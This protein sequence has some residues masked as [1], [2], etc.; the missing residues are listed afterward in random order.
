MKIIEIS[1]TNINNLKG[2]H[3][4]SF[5]KEPLSSAGIFA[6][7]GPTGAGKSSI[8]D[9]ITLALFNR[10]PRFKKSIT[11][12]EMNNAGSVMTHHCTEA[13]ASIIYE[14]KGIRFT[15][16]WSI[17]KTR[18]GNLKDYEMFIYNAQGQ[19]L[20]LKKSDVPTKNE[21]IIGLKYDQFI[22]SILLSQGEFAK[23]IKAD[24]NERGE[25]LENITGTSIYRTLGIKAFE[26]HK[27]IKIRITQEK[28]L[29]GNLSIL[30]KEDQ[31]AL[32]QEITNCEKQAIDL[33]K[34]ITKETHLKQIK[35][36]L[37]NINIELE[38]KETQSLR[39]AKQLKDFSPSLEKIKLHQK[40]NPIQA[41]LTTYKNAINNANISEKNLQDYSNQ[42]EKSKAD[43]N[44]TINEMSTLTHQKVDES[45]F[46]KTM[47]AFEKEVN[48]LD[49]ELR[50]ILKKGQEEREENIQLQ[51]DHQFELEDKVKPT[52][53]LKILQ[54]KQCLLDEIILNGK[55]DA[56]ANFN[57]YRK[58]LD[59]DKTRRNNFRELA[60][61]HEHLQEIEA[62]LV[63]IKES[64]E[65]LNRESKNLSPLIKKTKSLILSKEENI[66]LLLKQKE[67]ALK[68]ASLEDFRK[69]LT[70]ESPCP[71]CG[72]TEHPYTTHL[73]D[74]Q[75]DKINLKIENEQTFIK[76]TRVELNEKEAQFSKITANLELT[77]NQ[78]KDFSQKK[79]TTQENIQKSQSAFKFKAPKT[80]EALNGQIEQ[81]SQQITVDE[82]AIDAILE[83]EAIKELTKSFKQIQKIGTEYKNLKIKR[84]KKFK[85]ED[86][87]IVTNK[88]Q[89]IFQKNKS[90]ITEL[91]TVILRE[92]QSLKRDKDLVASI[93]KDL[94]PKVKNLGFDNLFAVQ[95]HFLGEDE[96]NTL[97]QQLDQ[98]NKTS[99]QNETELKT[100]SLK[101]KQLLQSDTEQEIDLELIS[102]NLNLNK[103][104]K[105]QL[106]KTTG[107]LQQRLKRDIEDRTKIES[108]QKQLDKLNLDLE[109]WG[110]L[111]EMIGDANGNKFANFAQGL[112]LQNLLVFA[113]RRLQTLSDRYLLDK[114]TDDGALMIVDLY[115]GNT[116]RSVTTLSGGESF[117]V[118][119]A[120]ALS[121]S[122]MAS[123]SVAL[124]SLF[125]DEGFGTLDQDTLEMA[126]NTLEKLQSESQKTIG[127]ISHVETLKER[128]HVQIQLKKNAQGYSKIEIA[129]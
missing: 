100:L 13:N 23:F 45:N 68:I 38:K 30:S 25:L 14:I 119:L 73:D 65:K 87:N 126:M 117:L 64:I 11:K 85:G 101:A 24:K 55:L 37:K 28:E 81:I 20:D 97:S 121:L 91:E 31:E 59:E 110:L 77:N 124:E 7:T 128:I 50:N 12:N 46:M 32:A 58:K 123:K 9:V 71:L 82:K 35:S 109:K 63:S 3:Q 86:V 33:E 94:S 21:Q 103:E 49:N 102:R 111:K 118:S 106:N 39:I 75:Q 6:I 54:E 99:T 76:K 62:Q 44:N 52:D 27:E 36:E 18:T 57:G 79:I 125:I 96:F 2:E 51:S 93:E 88:L 70:P 47:S 107:E 41:P 98:L 72:S 4:I 120:L 104:K 113:N 29:L 67:D 90:K 61:N 66:Q 53:A 105:D 89:D 114:P 108:K 92:T 84:E 16:S 42:L 10:I 127:V 56:D 34:S 95:D 17:A 8:L 5:E 1:F 26:K 129:S 48:Q 19:P 69:N 122:D 116:E 78:F 112:T 80:L 83:S 74:T 15:S 43:L 22:K 40:L 115:Q 60:H